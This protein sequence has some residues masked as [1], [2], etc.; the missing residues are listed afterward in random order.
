MA[1][2]EGGILPALYV[3]ILHFV[4]N[5]RLVMK[6]ASLLQNDNICHSERPKG[7]EESSKTKKYNNKLYYY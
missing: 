3:E 2:G 5:D 6:R 1:C 4:Q 7:A